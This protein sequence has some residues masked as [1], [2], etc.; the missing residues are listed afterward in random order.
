MKEFNIKSQ[1]KRPKSTRPK[2][3]EKDLNNIINVN[4]FR[5][6]PESINTELKDI[7][8]IIEEIE[9]SNEKEDKILIKKT[10]IKI[11]KENIIMSLRKELK[12]QK[13]LNRNLLNFKEYADKNSSSYKK[14]YEDICKYKA[15]LH[16]DLAE[17]ISI[18][19]NYEKMKN[20]YENEKN[21]IIKTNE[22]LINYKKEEQNKMKNRLNKLNFDTQDQ[23]NTIEKLRNT[24]REF[25]NQNNDF[26]LN[27]EKNEYDHDQRY[28]M[29]L[30]EYKRVENQYKYYYDLEMRSRKNQLDS[31][32]KNL[33]ADEEG[34]AISKLNDKQ[35]KGEFLKNVIRDIQSQIQEIENLNKR[36]KEDKEIEK[37]LGKRGAEKF[38]ERMSEKYNT[39]M[40][41]INSRYNITFTSL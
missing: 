15:Q 35:V 7:K 29:L 17:F 25:R 10:N 19:D 13:L 27:I 4:K 9:N 32:N 11:A 37:L 33:L 39:E 20:E 30:N 23:H 3:I 16:S 8:K 28:E 22:N 5:I 12:F 38:K 18:C 41:N 24:L 21:T 31:M 6:P 34:M 14:N 2:K 26:I 36:I 1:V 40:S